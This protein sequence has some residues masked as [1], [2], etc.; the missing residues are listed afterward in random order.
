[1]SDR[2]EL[3]PASPVRRTATRAAQAGISLIWLVPIL[4]LV[5]T[6]GLAFNAWRDRGELI[7]VEFAD[8]TGITPGETTLK[9]REVTV[10]QVESVSFTG[11][12][13]RVEVHI[14]VERSVAPYIGE[15]AQFWL[16]RPQVSAQGISRLDT[17]LSGVF[18]EG[19]WTADPGES[20]RRFTGLDR[21]PLTR[22]NAQG[23][24]VVL[25]SDDA[26]GLAEGAPV[27][28]RGL[29]IGR[30]ENLRLSARDETVQADVFISAPHDERLTSA[31]VFWNTSGFSVSIGAQGLSLNVDSLA[32]L[33]QG[34]VEF[35]T[36]VTGGIRVS[37]GHVFTLYPNEEAARANLFAGSPNELRL[38]MLV[39]ES[40]RGLS[41]GADV[42]YQGLTVG[43]VTDL[44]L[45]NR[46]D[47]AP[48]QQ[49]LQKL[50]LAIAPV[51]LGLDPDMSQQDIL[52]F[53]QDQVEHGLRARVAASGLFGTSLMIEL[54]DIPDAEPAE[55]EMEGDP[56][57]IMPSAPGDLSDFTASAQG[58]MARLG[59]LPIEELLKSATDMM[60]SVTAIAASQETRAI[61]ADIRA[62]LS[63]TQAAAADIRAVAAD[64]N[65]SGAAAKAGRLVDE[66]T[67]AAENVKLAAAEM[68]A[69]VEDI[70]SAARSFG[71]FDF[72]GISEQATLIMAD[73]RAMIGSDDAAELPRN[74]SATLKAAT[75]LLTDLQDGNAAGSLN[76][77]LA[78][79]RVAADEIATAARQMPEL[80]GRFQALAG[81]AQAVLGSYGERSAFQNDL[82]RLMLE[83]S[84]A[85]DSFASLARMIERNPRA[86][87]LGR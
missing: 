58:L 68:P 27:L 84:R 18:I 41:R 33:V 64:L 50:T 35:A 65:G 85:A 23:T 4:A 43:R 63:Q 40:V 13:Q 2:P 71:T 62:V 5:V 39:D 49:L 10:G 36:L 76:A 55:I 21:P 15:R 20:R 37:P 70:D 74:L 79:S 53:L 24:W 28:F 3:T 32:S 47:L 14:R 69:M 31:T 45:E 16:V 52:A 86:F 38:T 60:N 29:I 11:D 42:Q 61:P 22:H 87:I 80:A 77:L 8:A 34:G 56:Y 66:I 7:T 59:N 67:A 72:A 44:S 17:V 54:V 1:M 82:R 57:P 75:G 48:S 9:F 51:R 73:L 30:M 19:D 83:M 6:L 25:A 46:P 78:S 81:Q 12:L 26:K